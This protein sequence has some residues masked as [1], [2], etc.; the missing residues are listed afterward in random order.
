[1]FY[2]VDENNKISDIGFLEFASIIKKQIDK[3]K[4]ESLPDFH[5]V[6]VKQALAHF[7]DQIQ[8]KTTKENYAIELNTQQKK[9]VTYLKALLKLDITS[10]NEKGLINEAI[11]WISLGRYQ[12][13]PRDIARFQR[14]Q[15]KKPL[16]LAKQIEAVVDIINKHNPS[17][18]SVE[19]QFV[20]I[21]PEQHTTGNPSPKIVISQSYIELGKFTLSDE[22]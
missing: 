19:E 20:Q 18:S 15:K 22:L 7:N 5:H 4:A 21:V 6:Q 1:M 14:S 3:N 13:L 17:V 8:E 2:R 10:I 9:A 16:L 11:D 12:N